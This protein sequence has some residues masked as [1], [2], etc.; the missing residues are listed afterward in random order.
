MSVSRIKAAVAI[1]AS[2]LGAGLITS[3]ASAE[4]DTTPP[5]VPQNVQATAAVSSQN[6]VVSWDPSTDTGTGVKFYWVLVDGQNRAKPAATHY[7]I[8]ELVNLGR[9]TAGQHAITIRAVDY[10]LN[11]SAPSAPINIFVT[12]P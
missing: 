8:Q 2:L 9:I 11:F 1:A 4:A 3:T 6:P 12:V 5:S 10:A 7:D